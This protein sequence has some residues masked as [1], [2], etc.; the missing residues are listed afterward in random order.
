MT[1]RPDRLPERVA[2]TWFIETSRWYVEEHQGC[3]RCQRRHCVFQARWGS[4]VEYHC[5]GCDFS[6]AH[7]EATGTYAAMVGDPAPP[8]AALPLDVTPAPG[9]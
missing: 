5:T 1:I 2:Q 6:A 7:D 8:G 4:R 3:P 9:R